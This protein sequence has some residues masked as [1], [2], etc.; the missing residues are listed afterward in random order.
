MARTLNAQP[1]ATD[2]VY[3]IPGLWWHYSFE[4]LYLGAAP[5]HL[6]PIHS[7][8]PDM[9]RLPEI[10][11]SKLAALENVSTVKVVEWKTESRWIEDDT[12]P[13]AF[14]LSKYGRY[15]GSDEYTGFRVHNFLDIS[16]ARPWNF[17]DYL[18]PLT[19]HYDGGIS[20]HRL[21]LG[22]KEEQLSTQQLINLGLDRSLWGVLQW[23]T[24]PGL[25]VDY[26]ISLR[27]YNAEGERAYQAD[28]VI[29]KPTNIRLQASGR[30]MR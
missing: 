2:M 5:A 20:L 11:E 16:L 26:A 19:V 3:L 21:A 6:I 17:Y 12:V 27:L 14:L 28:D 22:Q 29:W 13:F 18:E 1:S 9:S 10:I 15:L 8:R 30:R 23:Q 25:D 24:S 4:Y 7:I